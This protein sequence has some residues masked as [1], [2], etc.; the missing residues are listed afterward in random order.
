MR[1]LLLR[2]PVFLQ[3]GMKDLLFFEVLYGPVL[4][5]DVGLCRDCFRRTKTN[6]GDIERSVFGR[7]IDCIQKRLAL[8]CVPRQYALDD[9]R[10]VL[11][12][13]LRYFLR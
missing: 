7:F 8:I 1:L 3:K 2:N 5:R 6:G 10:R 11:E 4:L 12:R 9:G 13:G